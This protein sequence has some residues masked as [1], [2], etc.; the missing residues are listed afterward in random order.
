VP[1]REDLNNSLDEGTAY[2]RISLVESSWHLIVKDPFMR[3]KYLKLKN[4]KAA[5]KAI[6]AIARI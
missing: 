1:G 3:F 4:R 2:E 6:I 5:K